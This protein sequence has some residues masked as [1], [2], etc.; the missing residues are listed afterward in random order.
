MAEKGLCEGVEKN[1]HKNEPEPE[2]KEGV[3][4]S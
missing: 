1:Y 2:D 3:P 4:K